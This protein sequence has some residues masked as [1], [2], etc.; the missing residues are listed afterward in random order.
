[1]HIHNP[2]FLNQ[3]SPPTIASALK[4]VLKTDGPVFSIFKHLTNQACSPF[5][6]AQIIS[7]AK[8]GL[9]YP[10]GLSVSQIDHL[11]ILPCPDHP[12]LMR[13][14]KL[15]RVGGKGCKHSRARFLLPTRR[16]VI[17]WNN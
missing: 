8:A 4:S 5:R 6:M 1:L 9:N 15:I 16:F 14:A 10:P 2:S 12:L 13:P 11:D 7:P 17:R 3:P